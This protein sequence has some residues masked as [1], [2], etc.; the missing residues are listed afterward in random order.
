MAIILISSDGRRPLLRTHKAM[1]T[2]TYVIVENR[3][4]LTTNSFSCCVS[5]ERERD[6]EREGSERDGERKRERERES[7]RDV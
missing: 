4:F 1:I 7:E 5:A 3:V 6:G 2:L